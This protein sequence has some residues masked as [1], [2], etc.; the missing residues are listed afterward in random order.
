MPKPEIKTVHDLFHTLWSNAVGTPDYNK[1]QWRLFN[2]LLSRGVTIN[3]QI[4]EDLKTYWY[5]FDK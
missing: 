2:E 1:A 3:M 5:G 4:P